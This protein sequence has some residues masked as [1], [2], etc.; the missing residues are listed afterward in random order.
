MKISMLSYLSA[1][2]GVIAYLNNL[3]KGMPGVQRT[4]LTFFCSVALLLG[5]QLHSLFVPG[6]YSKQHKPMNKVVNACQQD[7]HFSPFISLLT[8]GDIQVWHMEKG[9]LRTAWGQAIKISQP[10]R[11]STLSWIRCSFVTY[12]STSESDRYPY[13]R[14]SF[15]CQ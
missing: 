14:E 10:E 1:C 12:F 11:S 5:T 6:E 3:C 13:A 9:Q 4:S 2:E 15:I 8:R 7:L